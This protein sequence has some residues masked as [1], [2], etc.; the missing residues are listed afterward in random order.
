MKLEFG[1]SAGFIHKKSEEGVR[2]VMDIPL[3]KTAE[4]WPLNTRDVCRPRTAVLICEQI[5]SL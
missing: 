4:K 3:T 1:A 2:F 5:N